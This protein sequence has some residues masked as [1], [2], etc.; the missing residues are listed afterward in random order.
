[1]R[2]GS[3]ESLAKMAP[4]RSI[5]YA[6]VARTG[7]PAMY[8]IRVDS[9][10]DRDF[11][12]AEFSQGLTWE[13]LTEIVRREASPKAAAIFAEPIADPVRGQ[14]HWHVA[15]DA[16]PVPFK[17]LAPEERTRLL[18]ALEERRGAVLALADR[19]ASSVA[20]AD[21]RLAQAL[22]AS[23]TVPDPDA[24]IWSVGGEPLLVAWGRKANI[25]APREARMEYRRPVA[26]S[27][28]PAPSQAAFV[29]TAKIPEPPP[30]DAAVAAPRFIH[31]PA[32]AWPPILPWLSW[33][34][35]AALALTIWLNLLPA[36]AINTPV[37]KDLF[38]RCPGAAKTEM[39]QLLDRND[40]LRAAVRDAERRAAQS[41]ADCQRE[42][43]AEASPS[44][45]KARFARERGAAAEGRLIAAQQAS[46]VLDGPAPRQNSSINSFS[47]GY[48]TA[49][50]SP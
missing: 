20:E 12:P 22:R 26:P 48:S 8:S 36:C 43:K 18:S 27:A 41:A 37:L 24:H 50:T 7:G 23:V 29:G 4:P 19:L 16:D 21:V 39:D 33:L 15:T 42:K 6:R 34:A 5:G 46:G 30:R 25:A 1:M 47:K 45:T 31:P 40:E 49:W 10:N 13:R 11:P 35:F 44:G 32:F 28:P 38:D 14:T 9:T 3:F 2:P 17:R